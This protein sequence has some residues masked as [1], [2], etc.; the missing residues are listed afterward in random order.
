MKAND[1]LALMGN[2]KTYSVTIV[3]VSDI[4]WDYPNSASFHTKSLG[5]TPLDELNEIFRN[6]LHEA[7]LK[8]AAVSDKTYLL[9]G[10]DNIYK[11]R[12]DKDRVATLN[13]ELLLPTVNLAG[14][15]LPV[16]HG[17]IAVPGNHDSFSPHRNLPAADKQGTHGDPASDK[18]HYFKQICAELQTSSKVPI[19]FVTPF[20]HPPI[21]RIVYARDTSYGKE[22]DTGRDKSISIWAVN[23]A[24]KCG[25]YDAAE[26]RLQILLRDLRK[27]VSNSKSRSPAVRSVIEQVETILAAYDSPEKSYDPG[28]IDREAAKACERALSPADSLRIAVL[29]HNNL[30]TNNDDTNKYRFLN[31]SYFNKFLVRNRFRI[32]LHGHQ[33]ISEVAAYTTF[34]SSRAEEYA[35]YLTDGFLAIGAPAFDIGAHQAGHLGFNIV[36]LEVSS[37]HNICRVGVTSHL[38]NEEANDIKAQTRVH[39][40]ALCE[41][42]EKERLMALSGVNRIIFSKS[43]LR[44]IARSIDSMDYDQNH[45][46][47]LR[48][49]LS[50]AKE[51][52][53]MY[54]LSVFTPINWLN[55]KLSDLF[56]SLGRLNIKRAA[57]AYMRHKRK[58]VN[59]DGLLFQFSKPLLYALRGATAN[60]QV[61]RRLDLVALASKMKE[62]QY[63][64]AYE[65]VNSRIAAFALGLRSMS[66][67]GQAISRES[68]S[69]A[70]LDEALAGVTDT[71]VT[72]GA[73]RPFANFGGVF[74]KELKQM[75]NLCEFPRI[76]L[77]E[78][79]DFLRPSALDIILFH[80]SMGFPLFWLD[81]SLIKNSQ[82]LRRNRIG[83]VSIIACRRSDYDIQS[84]KEL[85][86]SPDGKAIY[87][88]SNVADLLW[89]G[90]DVKLWPLA[91]KEMGL[92]KKKFG[93]LGRSDRALHEYVWLLGHPSLCFAA[94]AWCAKQA[95][96]EI[97]KEFRRRLDRSTKRK[98]PRRTK[99]SSSDRAS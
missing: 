75:S 13:E 67:F 1:S 70:G 97:W 90:S 4:H 43:S 99:A 22:T 5:G 54:A 98:A 82:G 50:N 32:I 46:A 89:G 83:Y 39:D 10:G 91:K 84:A 74:K 38:W 17:V 79:E 57:Y 86:H 7:A 56:S 95:G 93:K 14:K 48:N 45:S 92:E 73:T 37:E 66:L 8:A 19:T 44:G 11:S 23:S 71:W 63:A 9:L 27:K 2:R 15:R 26:E 24:E 12:W 64:Q 3:H 96:G 31:A 77:W 40:I 60:S 29:H 76:V 59:G 47:P 49:E 42:E 87:Q 18:F 34:Q 16:F 28:S 62:Q 78:E 36:R 6:T 61:L 80:E 41:P 52:K 88:M 65:F 33:H 53:A 51:I 30:P 94:D 69:N 25:L 55:A 68:A 35:S 20:S 85:F 21:A 81:A 58:S 72:E